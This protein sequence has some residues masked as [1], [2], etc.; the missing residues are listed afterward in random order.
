M[1]KECDGQ[2]RR[3]DRG[4]DGERKGISNRRRQRREKFSRIEGRGGRLRL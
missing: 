1:E 4:G 3:K 2:I